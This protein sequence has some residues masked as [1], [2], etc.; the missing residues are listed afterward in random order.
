MEKNFIDYGERI[1]K[2]LLQ[3]IK[4]ILSDLSASKISSNHCFYITFDTNNPNVMMSAKL[5]KEYPKE[6]TIVIQNQ[7]WNLEINKKSFNVTLSFNR[8]KETLT[9]PFDSISKFNDPF[10]KF[11]LQLEFRSKINKENEEK[12]PLN[13]SKTKKVNKKIVR[14]NNQSNKI[15]KLDKFRK[16]KE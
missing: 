4:D 9:I 8:K 10:V 14:K 13:N 6:I 7:F 1:N 15:I 3:V 11:S 2:A 12:K 16:K 5:K